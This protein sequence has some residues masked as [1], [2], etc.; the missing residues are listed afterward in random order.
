[1]TPKIGAFQFDQNKKPLILPDQRLSLQ[2]AVSQDVPAKLLSTPVYK[3][4]SGRRLTG[5]TVFP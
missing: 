2:L 4:L 1:M 5:V 3:G